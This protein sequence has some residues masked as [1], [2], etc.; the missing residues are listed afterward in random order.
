MK[1]NILSIFRRDVA[2]YVFTIIITLSTGL[3]ATEY[4]VTAYGNNKTD[5]EFEAK[6]LL[7]EQG[8]GALVE[9]GSAS[10]DTEL[11]YKF[12]S[13]YTKGYINNFKII[14][15]EKNGKGYMVQAT[16]NVD[17]VA[18]GSAIEERKKEIG[19]PKMMI[20]MSETLFGKKN[21]PGNTKSEYIFH[22]EM[23]KAGFDFVDEEMMKKVLAREKG[24][25]VGAYGN[26]K[27]EELAMKVA[28]ELNTDVLVIGDTVVKN[29]GMISGGSGIYTYQSDINPHSGTCNK[30]K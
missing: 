6:L 12:V 27:L 23:K 9:G 19:N 14:K 2:R 7:I 24:L 15:Q 26:P 4:E 13:S 8:I 17:L 28:A 18:M 22:S 25:E 30:K 5:A 1:K 3:L 20:L 21:K 16:G 10:I 11:Q 29:A